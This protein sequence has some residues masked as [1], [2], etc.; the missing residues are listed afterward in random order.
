MKVADSSGGSAQQP[1]T[2]TVTVPLST[3]C[4]I[5][6]ATFGRA[7]FSALIGTG[8]SGAGYIWSLAGGSLAP[9]ALDPSGVVSGS[10]TTAVVLNFT[11]KITDSAGT[12]DLQPCTI[13]FTSLGTSCPVFEAVINVA[14]SSQLVGFGGSGGGYKWTLVSGSL[15]AA[16]FER[17]RVGIWNPKGRH[18]LDL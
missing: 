8:G 3:T 15:E 10:A 9:L 14:Y 4:P 17:G 5:A 2:L 6:T 7:Y 11:L 13:N 1:C 18:H 16:E 12:T